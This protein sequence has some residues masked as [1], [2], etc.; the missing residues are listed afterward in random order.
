MLGTFA[1]SLWLTWGNIFI[2]LDMYY[3][4][5]SGSWFSQ[6]KLADNPEVVS[7]RDRYNRD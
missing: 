7:Y 4:Q 3:R 6:H 1:I 5:I 2:I